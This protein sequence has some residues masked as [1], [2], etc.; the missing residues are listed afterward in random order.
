MGEVY[1]AKDTRLDRI[2]AVKV[3]SERHALD[4]TSRARFEREARAI[5]SLNH[6]HI[7]T[8]HDVGSDAGIDYLVM[9]Y[10]HGETLAERLRKRALP[11]AEALKYATQIGDAL[12]KAHRAGVVHRDLKPSNVMLTKAGAKLLD[13]GLAKLRPPDARGP[14]SVATEEAL[15][16]TGTLLG[17][18]PYMAPEQLEGKEAD[19][20]TDIFALGTMLYEMLTGRPAFTGQSQAGLI[21]AI[22]DSNPQPI[23]AVKPLTPPALDRIVVVCLAKDPDERWQSARDVGLALK[24]IGD[25]ESQAGA[26]APVAIGSVT[27]ERLAWTA[28]AITS[29]LLGVATALS[30]MPRRPPEPPRQVQLQI[31]TPDNMTFAFQPAISPDGERVAFAAYFQLTSQL[32]IRPLNAV[33][34]TAIPGA[35]GDQPFWSPD[36]RELGYSSLGSLEKVDLSSGARQ[37]LCRLPG[38]LLGASWNRNGVIVFSADGK[39]FRVASSG[40]EPTPLGTP[41]DGELGRFWPYF[42]PDGRHYLYLSR[43]SRAD[44]RGV[45]VASIDSGD[46]KRVV[47]SNHN[48]A[49]ASGHL[50][51][52]RGD[53]LVAQPFDLETFDLRGDAFPIAERI[54]PVRS[55]EPGVAYSVSANGVLAWEP[56]ASHIVQLTWFHRSGRKLSTLGEAAPYWSP[57]LAPDETRLAVSQRDEQ[58]GTR[59]LWLFDLPGGARRRL[60]FDP[61]DDVNP[62]WSPD[63]S[64]IAFA[65]NRTGTYEIYLKLANGAGGDELLKASPNG[66]NYVEDWSSDGTFLVY[67]HQPYGPSDIYLLPLFGNRQP[68]PVTA[69]S[70]GDDMG[71]VTTSGRWVAYRSQESGRSEIYVRRVSPEGPSDAGKWQVSTEGGVEPRWRGDGKELYYM[72]GPALMAVAVKTAGASFEAG[73]PTPLF[74]ARLPF[75]GGRNRYIVTRDGQRFLFAVLTEQSHQPIR[76]TVNALPAR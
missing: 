74:E 49:Y 8:V 39:L 51:F 61:A 22:L 63:G 66:P 3:L 47:L 32:Y 68:I 17:T 73:T 11:P 33:A 6:P 10:V 18:V 1:K 52:V 24:S 48:A 26:P 16:E 41:A 75:A 59:D 65:S 20:R 42:L 36:G 76:V 72:S 57:A 5:S 55:P 60:T 56:A 45:Y 70:V 21:A 46:R 44:D 13:F 19:E 9:E 23:S 7:C 27:R 31:L 62:T 29:A 12:D 25:G 37:T 14:H 2:V 54:A 28:A 4:D 40:G 58:T 15:T 43:S 35:Q 69:T 67:N 50:L 30:L 71:Q 34:A 38:V 53:A 64:R